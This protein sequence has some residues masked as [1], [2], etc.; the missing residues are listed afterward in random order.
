LPESEGGKAREDAEESNI[1][2]RASEA[3]VYKPDVSGFA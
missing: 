1:K 2:G 3:K